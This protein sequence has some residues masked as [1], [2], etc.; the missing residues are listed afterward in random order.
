MR[1]CLVL[2]ITVLACG[3]PGQGA[4][5]AGPAGP[6]GP[7]ACVPITCADE[8]VTCG[9][10]DD[11]C[12]SELACGE[13]CCVSTTCADEGVTCGVID[14]GCGNQLTCGESCDPCDR[15]GIGDICTADQQ[16]VA[17]ACVGNECF[18]DCASACGEEQVC[19]AGGVSQCGQEICTSEYC[20][21][22]PRAT[23]WDVEHLAAGGGELYL[24]GEVGV[25]FAPDGNVWSP[26]VIQD[27]GFYSTVA[28][29][30]AQ[31]IW[32]MQVRRIPSDYQGNRFTEIFELDTATG[33]TRQIGLPS[34]GYRERVFGGMH[35]A[36]PDLVVLY[37]FCESTTGTSRRC[38]QVWDG[39]IWSD[40]RSFSRDSYYE[41]ADGPADSVWLL[42]AN[43]ILERFEPSGW[44]LQ[45]TPALEP[46][47]SFSALRVFAA[48]NAWLATELGHVHHWNGSGWN[49][50]SG[51]TATGVVDMAGGDDNL[52]FLM[53]SAAGSRLVYHWNGQRFAV[54]VDGVSEEFTR[55]AVD[56]STGRIFLG[57]PSGALAEG[58]G[59]LVQ[60]ISNQI[61]IAPAISEYVGAPSD[62]WVVVRDENADTD[63]PPAGPQVLHWD[64][65]LWSSAYGLLDEWIE[66]VARDE[67][68]RVFAVGRSGSAFAL[69]DHE[70]TRLD[71][72]TQAT[73]TRVVASAGV[74]WA[75][76]DDGQILRGTAATGLA[77]VGQLAVAV[78]D[79]ISRSADELLV[80]STGTLHTFDGVAWSTRSIPSAAQKLAGVGDVLWATS[81]R[82]SI[83]RDTP[84]GWIPFA[85]DLFSG[86]ADV[87]P[88]ADGTAW[89]F[90]SVQACPEIGCASP[91][92]L[93]YFDGARLIKIATLP[94]GVEGI[95]I[96]GAA[97]DLRFVVNSYPRKAGRLLS[98]SSDAIQRV[99]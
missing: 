15:C 86:S 67:E 68:G 96:G 5:D 51:F 99:P 46:S 41:H 97:S 65:N 71:T 26:F 48:D 16:C 53:T 58:R 17:G 7:R 98:L 66:S 70:W 55:I 31:R 9:T 87:A 84:D 85:E 47:D 22:Y 69:E 64:G 52:Y 94:S 82:R 4:T 39:A 74:I 37:G 50:I 20:W 32:S 23:G 49:E 59:G 75:A 81:T 45:D 80:L 92:E 42:T 27:G 56:D 76:T 43:D 2:F 35:V 91:E 8:G 83:W 33:T 13:P 21:Q 24:G 14:D 93:Y 44:T 19:H 62:M 79:M 54:A 78:D 61:S 34:G 30:D 60:P 29:L 25:A 10:L 63:S 88:R 3:S 11:G 6:D 89:V 90:G 73:L 36:S 18:A 12:G 77:T 40:P 38:I 1:Y 95:A 28:R 72:D 57:G